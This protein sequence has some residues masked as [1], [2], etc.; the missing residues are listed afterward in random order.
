MFVMEIELH[1]EELETERRWNRAQWFESAKLDG[2]LGRFIS[3]RDDDMFVWL[4]GFRGPLP[5][6]SFVKRSMKRNLAPAA[7]SAITELRDFV[8]IAESAILEIRQYRIVPGMRG[9][10]ATFLH[11]RTLEAHVRLGMPIYGQFDDL[12]DEN[13]FVFLRGFPSLVER[14]RRKAEFYQGAYWLNEL[15]DEAFSMIEDYS[16]VLLVTPLNGAARA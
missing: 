14:D 16:N 1:I 12:D 8:R 9:R 3:L 11:D 2:V 7:G 13:V 5:D 4:R 6:Q 10:F 15:Q